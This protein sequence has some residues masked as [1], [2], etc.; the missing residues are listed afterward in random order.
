[1]SALI[2]S[3]S[4]VLQFTAAVLAWR[5][6]SVT[7]RRGAWILIALALAFMG[8]RRCIT[9]YRVMSGDLTLP[10]DLSAELVAL[11]ISALLVAGVGLIGPMFAGIRRTQEA[12]RESETNYRMIVANIAEAF[13]RADQDGRLVMI[14]KA[15]EQLLGFTEAEVL[16]VR[17]ADLYVD[18]SAREQFLQALQQSG[19][20]VSGYEAAMRHADGSVVW[21]STNA[22][23]W[24]DEHGT[25][26]GVEGTAR[27]ITRQK[28]DEARIQVAREEAE[29]ANRAK[30]EFLANM[31]HELRT[32]LNAVSGFAQILQQR[33]YGD[34]ND[35]QA[36]YVADIRK[37]GDLLLELIDD[38]LDLSKIEAG[39][40]DMDE[41][42][43]VLG[44]AIGE[45]VRFVKE[46]ARDGGLR[47]SIDAGDGLPRLLADRRRVK[48][49]LLNLLS[50]AIKFTNQGGRVTVTAG[51][52]DDG[53]LAL[54]VADTGIGMDPAEIPKALSMFG[55]IESFVSKRHPGSG[56]GLALCRSL[57]RLHGADLRIESEPGVGT[58]VTVIFPP[59]R[60]LAG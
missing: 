34:L 10:A 8:V 11:L 3:L 44:E 18:P 53:G 25:L 14:S 46:R 30:T 29:I 51:R 9:F 60:T 54:S 37:S 23:Y 35:K 22:Q 32:P 6:I 2:L 19:G 52:G 57:A 20:R 36:E 31:S 42:P 12:L 21:V 55:Q 58:T 38:V 1:M 26:L 13:Y 28:N 59:E 40:M 5:L 27:D 33:Y 15:A 24:R 45:A 50:N 56:L 17:L 4:I 49:I 43:M 41:Q 7:G 47:L 39:K 16:G 48:Q